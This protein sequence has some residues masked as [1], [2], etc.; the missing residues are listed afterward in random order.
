MR[1]ES[2]P[3]QVERN[4]SEKIASKIKNKVGEFLI[5]L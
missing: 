5:V 3:P 4:I 1:V 2:V